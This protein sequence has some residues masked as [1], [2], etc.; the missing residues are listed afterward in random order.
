MKQRQ[1]TRT[2]HTRYPRRHVP[3][4]DPDHARLARNQDPNSAED[5]YWR[6]SN[7]S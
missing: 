3:L 5:D 1:Q 4:G 2:V 6:L 7:R